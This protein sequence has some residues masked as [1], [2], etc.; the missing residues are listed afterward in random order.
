[1]SMLQPWASLLIE[2]FKRVEGRHWTTAH[3]GPLWI[4]AGA[5]PPTVELV[6]QIEAQYDK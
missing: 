6:S 1:M 3:R 5:T 4:H 2:G